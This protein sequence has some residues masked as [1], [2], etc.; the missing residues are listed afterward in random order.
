MNDIIFYQD[1]T[2]KSE[3]L[4]FI[5]DLD[6]RAVTSKSERVMLKQ[7]RFHI[8]ILEMN[9][10]RAGE[11]YVKH[12]QDEVWEIRPG[13]NRILFFAWIDNKIVLLHQF[14]KTTKKTPKSEVE[15]AHRE[16]LDWKERNDK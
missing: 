8:N 7:I 4:E 3:L 14:R 15:K 6:K 9:G 12:I 5:K 11:P 16:I 13:N 1:G 10:T 2:G